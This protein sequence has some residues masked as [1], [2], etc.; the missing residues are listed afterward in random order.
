MESFV[1]HIVLV[2]LGATAA[3]WAFAHFLAPVAQ[4]LANLPL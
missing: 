3:G 2:S 1:P 4:T